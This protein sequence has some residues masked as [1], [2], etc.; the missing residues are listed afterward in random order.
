MT[1]P[2]VFIC[3]LFVVVL[4]LQRAVISHTSVFKYSLH[5]QS[6]E[7]GIG[8][9]IIVCWWP[10]LPFELPGT[11]HPPAHTHS[12]QVTFIPREVCGLIAAYLVSNT[13]FPWKDK[14]LMTLSLEFSLRG[15]PCQRLQWRPYS[16]CSWVFLAN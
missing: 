3:S 4:G 11:L 10:E 12:L 13:V 15:S 9:L 16:L 2:F 7:Q 1:M 14:G 5:P 6:S 8:G